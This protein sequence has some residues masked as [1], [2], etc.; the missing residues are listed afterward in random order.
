MSSNL[1]LFEPKLETVGDNAYMPRVYE[2]KMPCQW[3]MNCYEGKCP[4][5]RRKN[6]NLYCAKKSRP[7]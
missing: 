7:S 4:A 6:G 1:Q 2:V 3:L 5:L